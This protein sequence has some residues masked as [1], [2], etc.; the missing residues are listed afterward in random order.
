MAKQAAREQKVQTLLQ[1]GPGTY[2]AQLQQF[3]APNL[4][5]VCLDRLHPVIT[6]L[7]WDLNSLQSKLQ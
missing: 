5:D 1:A 2:L 7:F 4:S 3:P 6:E